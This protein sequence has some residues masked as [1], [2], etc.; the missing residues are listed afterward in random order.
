M[1]DIQQSIIIRTIVRIMIPF[2][3]LFS[4]YVIMHGASGPGGGFQGGVIFGAGI[5]LYAMIYGIEEAKKKISDKANRI[6]ASGGL[7][8]YAGTGLLAILFGG[9]FLEYGVIPLMPTT[10]YTAK[11]LIDV[12]EIG[13]GMTV[14]AVM[15]SL[16]FDISPPETEEDMHIHEEVE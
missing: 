9:M 12:V 14:L 6:L 16:F 2:I 4:L 5:I 10:A 7:V 15:I 1:S 13:I 3:L 11:I 8:L